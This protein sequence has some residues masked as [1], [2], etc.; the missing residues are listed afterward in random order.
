MAKPGRRS[1]RV[2]AA[3]NPLQ[4]GSHPIRCISKP[5]IAGLLL[6]HSSG[7][8][9]F[10]KPAKLAALLATT[11]LGSISGVL[12]AASEGEITL[13]Y[14]TVKAAYP[15]FADYCRLPDEERRKL[16]V[17]SVMALA[18]QRKVSDPIAAGPLAGAKLRKECGL[19]EVVVDP[20]AIRWMTSAKPLDFD[21]G[22]YVLRAET[23]PAELA[24]RVF[25]PEGSGPFP[26]VVVSQTK[27][28]S[29]HLLVHAKA[30][31]AAGYAVLVVDT[32]GPRGYRIGVNEPFPAE[33]AKDAYDALAHL[34]KQAYINAS[35]IY[36]TGYSNGGNAAALLASPQGAK[37]LKA[38]GR[39]RA[40]VANY[41]TCGISGPY[42]GGGKAS[43]RLELLSA[44]SDKPIL[45]LMGEL[46]IES[47][48]A[49][50]FPLL[51]QMKAA[52]K[53]VEW[54]IYPKTAHGWDKRENN[55]HVYR[56][57]SGETMTY[58]YDPTITRDATE[59]MLAFFNKYR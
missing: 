45:L 24:N 34:S 31:I 59:R 29:E 39:F 18:T 50:C 40:T 5:A 43:V 37:A 2:A 49:N 44:D 1:A 22:R 57:I 19:D 52:G 20:S 17:K 38:S 54:H 32:F 7:A 21:E 10:A 23:K 26:A 53:P 47:P 27:S 12:H 56:T 58:T 33:F 11:I 48:P 25:A 28:V 13:I 15:Q 30:L 46:D 4:Q 9:M 36:Q 51:E 55:G 8:T 42:G 6:Y 3:A 41:G 14:E 35:R 16:V